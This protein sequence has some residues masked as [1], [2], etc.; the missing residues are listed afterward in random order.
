MIK[1]KG[2]LRYRAHCLSNGLVEK[3]LLHQNTGALWDF[4]QKC[5]VKPSEK[6]DFWER[7]YFY[8]EII[9]FNSC[10]QDL[11]VCITG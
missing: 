9:I 11:N 1:C 6:H 5:A 10:Q 7:F 4:A 8:L 3:I 2:V